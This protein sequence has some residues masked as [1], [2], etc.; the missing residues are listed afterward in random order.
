MSVRAID[1]FAGAGGFSTGAHMAGV[2]VVWAANHWPAAVDVHAANHPETEHSCQD[3]H[4]A[5]WTKVPAH[6][7]YPMRTSSSAVMLVS[8]PPIAVTSQ[9]SRSKWPGMSSG[10]A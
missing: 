2:E 7:G 3:L 4:Q 1:L 9:Y 6:D 8:V 10:F 5:D